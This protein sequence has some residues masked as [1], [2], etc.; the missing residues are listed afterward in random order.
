MEKTGCG[1]ETE[2]GAEC[3][4]SVQTGSAEEERKLT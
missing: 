4:K 2:A 1:M 3:M